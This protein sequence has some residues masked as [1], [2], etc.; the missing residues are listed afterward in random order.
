[1][2]SLRSIVS[3][4]GNILTNTIL[5]IFILL[6][7]TIPVG[8]VLSIRIIIN[9][10]AVRLHPEFIPCT[11]NDILVVRETPDQQKIVTGGI[12]LRVRGQI[13]FT[14][15]QGLFQELFLTPD[16]FDR[17]RNL[18][19]DL[20]KFCGYLF[21]RVV[22]PV[23]GVNGR[24]INFEEHFLKQELTAGRNS[25]NYKEVIAKWFQTQFKE[26]LPLWQVLYLV[27]IEENQSFLAV[28][29]HHGLMD[30]YS[31]VHVLDKLT[32]NSSPCLVKENEGDGTLWKE[33]S[34]VLNFLHCMKFQQTIN[35]ILK[36]CLQIKLLFKL[37]KV[38]LSYLLRHFWF[39]DTFPK[40]PNLTEVEMLPVSFGTADLAPIKA[41][42]R[43]FNVHFPSI[44]YSLQVGAIRRSLLERGTKEDELSEV[45]LLTTSFPVRGHP[46]NVFTN[47]W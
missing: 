11:P 17:Y 16:N 5:W 22:I 43:S 2:D 36:N 27:D 31:L 35:R 30:G 4:V 14:K 38:S 21:K 33:V 18:Y 42:R 20:V 7:Y 19:C 26:G 23:N 1:M 6:I 45:T 34:H 40:L 29:A 32:G 10:I 25:A 3:N 9:L 41:I 24:T 46:R 28:K 13:D 44:I 39:P 47:H 12:I 15:F 8:L 37:P